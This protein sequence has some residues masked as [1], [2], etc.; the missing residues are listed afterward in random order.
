M[1]SLVGDPATAASPASRREE[2]VLRHLSAYLSLLGRYLL[3]DLARVVL[4]GVL[5]LSGI[6][7]NVANPQFIRH[8]I[9]LAKQQGDRLWRG[10]IDE[11]GVPADQVP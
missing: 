8:F 5:L 9:D 6:G 7:L 2:P 4:L 11:L 1:V 3:P 10:E